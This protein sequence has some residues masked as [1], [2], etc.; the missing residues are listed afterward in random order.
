MYLIHSILVYI[1]TIIAGLGL[2]SVH[3]H[4]FRRQRP[5]LWLAVFFDLVVGG[6][7]LLA[8]LDHSTF[9]AWMQEDTWVEWAT[10]YA[11]AAAGVTTWLWLRK[12]WRAQL[13]EDPMALV[14]V[15]GVG[16]FCVFVAAEEISWGQRL[17]AFTPP[18]IFLEENYQQELNIHNFL[19]DKEL[20]GFPLDTRYL[21]ALVAIIYGLVLV[22]LKHAIK[23]NRLGSALAAAA[24]PAILVPWFAIVA[25]VELIYPVSFSGEAAEFVLGLLFLAAALA[26]APTHVKDRLKAPPRATRTLSVLS[27]SV[28][29]GLATPPLV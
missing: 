9:V 14:A 4:G 24:P 17:F 12:R 28:A 15:F 21:V 29:L 13:K 25:L 8:L 16:L 6:L 7:A 3:I 11:F 22:A 20:A 10:F 19:K 5:A 23:D 1:L 26:R 2:A 18:E 27:A